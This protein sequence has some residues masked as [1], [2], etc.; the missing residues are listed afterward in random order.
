MR[1]S[2]LEAERFGKELA[3]ANAQVST[4]VDSRTK[5]NVSYSVTSHCHGMW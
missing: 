2:A 4:A 1:S 5:D 3:A